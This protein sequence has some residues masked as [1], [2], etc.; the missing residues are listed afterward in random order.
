MQQADM[1][2]MTG[3]EEMSAISGKAAE[4]D[5]FCEL[6][7]TYQPTGYVIEHE[8]KS[9]PGLIPDWFLLLHDCPRDLCQRYQKTSF[10]RRA[11]FGILR[12]GA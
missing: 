9:F 8:R 2:L 1:I 11:E 12:V 4:K 5:F 10:S 7:Y 6:G 3:G